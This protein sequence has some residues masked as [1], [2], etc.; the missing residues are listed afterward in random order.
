M[1]WG[2][3]KKVFGHGASASRNTTSTEEPRPEPITPANQR[4]TQQDGHTAAE[5][6]EPSQPTMVALDVETTGFSSRQGDRIVSIALIEVI[7]TAEIGERLE[8]FVDPGRDIPAAATA[9]HG[10]R[11]EDVRGKAL[12]FAEAAPQVVEFIG[13]RQI[14]GYNLG[15]DLG[16]LDAEFTIA[17]IRPP[18]GLTAAGLDAMVLVQAIRGVRRMKLWDACSLVGAELGDLRA[19]SAIDDALATARLFQKLKHSAPAATWTQAAQQAAVSLG[20][21]RTCDRYYDDDDLEQGWLLFQAKRYDQA[22]ARARLAI[23]RDEA[24]RSETIESRGYEQAAMILRR[25]KRPEDERDVLLAFLRRALGKQPSREDIREAARAPWERDGSG[26]RSG[27]ASDQEGPVVETSS[28]TP[29]PTEGRRPAPRVYELAARLN[30]LLD[31]LEAV[32]ETPAQRLARCIAAP[33]QEIHLKELAVCLRKEVAAW[34]AR[35]R[36]EGIRWLLQLYGSAQT[37]AFLHGPYENGPSDAELQRDR[38]IYLSGWLAADLITPDDLRSLV[39]GYAEVGYRH[40]PLLLK[41]D[42]NRLVEA[43]GEPQQHL[44]VRARHAKIWD[45]IRKAARAKKREMERAYLTPTESPLSES[46]APL[47]CDEAGASISKTS[48]P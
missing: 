37:H 41:T 47:S 9:V 46:R 26:R 39:L 13:Q 5:P 1:A 22:L 19:H 33:P 10:I 16:F 34:W 27:E 18:P 29:G 6:P 42:I 35:D 7:G 36:S 32:P 24:G 3:L 17:G 30:A 21:V 28:L 8:V 11:T 48:Y 23:E 12:T 20:S 40:L 31:T 2:I 15:F 4:P 38:R 43:F 44:N 45:R 14:I 25:C